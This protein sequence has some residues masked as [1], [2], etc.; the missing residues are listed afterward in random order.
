MNGSAPRTTRRRPST[1][2]AGRAAD[3]PD[4]GDRD[5]RAPPGRA[6]APRRHGRRRGDGAVVS[7]QPERVSAGRIRL[8]HYRRVRQLPHAEAAAGAAG[9]AR[10][11]AA[12]CSSS[13]PAPKCSIAR[14]SQ[15][16]SRWEICSAVRGLRT[17]RFF[18]GAILGVTL[19]AIFLAYQTGF[20]IVANKLGA[21][22]PAD[23]PY[24]DL[25]N[26]KFPWLFVLLGGYLPAISEEFML[27]H[28]R[29]PVSAE[30]GALAAG[31]HRAGGVHLGVRARR[32]SQSAVLHSRPGSG[33]RRRGAGPDHAPLGHSADA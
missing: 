15:E 9:R 29:H 28:V 14:R 22:S 2:G 33:D 8:S 7:V 25:L 5:A 11:G 32:I 13:P 20:Y 3:R 17:K 16:R 18:L 21:W 26:T 24:S 10:A 6:L 19:C 12:R 27:S 31:G 30:T 4:R 1:R 23:V